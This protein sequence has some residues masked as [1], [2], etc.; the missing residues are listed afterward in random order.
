MAAHPDLESA[1]V[2]YL[3]DVDKAIESVRGISAAKAEARAKKLAEAKAGT[4]IWIE[5]EARAT[6]VGLTELC[7]TIIAAAE[8]ASVIGAQ[9]E[10]K[11]IYYRGLIR[12]AEKAAEMQTLLTQLEESL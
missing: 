3:S 5:A 6:G 2:K 7:A 4:G 8:E 10:A 1:R 12:Q 11:R 9:L